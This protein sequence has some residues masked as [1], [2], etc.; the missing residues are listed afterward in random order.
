MRERRLGASGRK[1]FFPDRT[2][3][4]HRRK[5]LSASIFLGC[6]EVI[7]PFH[8]LRSPRMGLRTVNPRLLARNTIN[9]L[10]HDCHQLLSLCRVTARGSVW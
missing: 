10:D 8:P 9:A 5:A 1:A 4:P 6:E 7:Q 3:G 2:T